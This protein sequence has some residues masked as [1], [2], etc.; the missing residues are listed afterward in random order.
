MRFSH[1]YVVPEARGD[2]KGKALTVYRYHYAKKHPE[3]SRIDALAAHSPGLYSD[4][5]M[6]LVDRRGEDN[7]IYYMAAELD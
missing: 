1:C 6:E 4:F 2:G 3:C 5:G 7:H